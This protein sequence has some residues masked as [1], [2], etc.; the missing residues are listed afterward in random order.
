MELNETYAPLF[1]RYGSP[2]RSAEFSR[3]YTHLYRPDL[4]ESVESVASYDGQA[5]RVIAE[6][7]RLIE[8]MT[9][10]RQ[11]LVIRYNE[12]ATMT[13]REEITLERINCYGSIS[14]YLRFATVYEDGTRCETAS[15]RYEGKQRHKAIARFEALKK[16]RRNAEFIKDI[17]KKQWERR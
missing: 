15:E 7:Q 11:D 17:D 12:L 5:A 8:Q 13:S 16:E 2:T 1:E 6:C 3:S 4:I 14:Y 9:A 10:Y